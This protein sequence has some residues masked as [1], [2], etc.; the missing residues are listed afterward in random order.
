MVSLAQHSQHHRGSNIVHSYR[1]LSIN[2][3]NIISNG[4]RF[5]KTDEESSEAMLRNKSIITDFSL[6]FDAR[7]ILYSHHIYTY[8][9]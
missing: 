9:I 1:S 3:A 2:D 7:W 8:I 6:Q 4:H 5:G